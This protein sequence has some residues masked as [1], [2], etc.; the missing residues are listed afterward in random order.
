M[1]YFNKGVG[2]FWAFSSGLALTENILLDSNRIRR[3]LNIPRTQFDKDRP[4]LNK[5]NLFKND[6]KQ[7]RNTVK[8]FIQTFKN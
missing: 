7:K 2:L 5:F 4:Y 8:L 3:L 1:D 6:L